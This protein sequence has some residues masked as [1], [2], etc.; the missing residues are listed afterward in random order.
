MRTLETQKTEA[1]NLEIVKTVKA[2]KLDN[3]HLTAFLKAY[4]KGDLVLPEAYEQELKEGVDN[5]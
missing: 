2:V 4:A 5:E 1:E 3:K